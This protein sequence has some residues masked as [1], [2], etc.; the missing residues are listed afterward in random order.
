MPIP[1]MI[2][3]LR[4]T[5]LYIPH[6][7][8][9]AKFC[10]VFDAT[11]ATDKGYTLNTIQMTGP[12]LQPDL[13]DIVHDFRTG[14]IGVNTDIKKMFRRVRL[15]EDQWN[16]QRLFWRESKKNQLQEYW[17]TVVTYGIRSSPYNAVKNFL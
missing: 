11:A 2:W 14:K 6:H 15:R 1:Q 10:V 16:L 3:V 9:L 7:P 13:V 17:L 5:T 4:V 12:K 8:V